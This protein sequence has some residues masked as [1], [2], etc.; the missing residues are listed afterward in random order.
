MRSSRSSD[1][2][3]VT[4]RFSLRLLLVLVTLLAMSCVCTNAFINRNR[5][6][7]LHE[8]AAFNDHGVARPNG[9]S[10]TNLD[11]QMTPILPERILTWLPV[12]VQEYFWRITHLDISVGTGFAD[13]FECCL[14][15]NRVEVVRVGAV[16]EPRDLLATLQGFPNL[17][18]L[19]V[20]C[21]D[22]YVNGQYSDL[23]YSELIPEYLPHVTVIREGS[24]GKVP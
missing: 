4:P 11:Y 16:W 19:E 9:Y 23:G 20:V 14:P 5:I 7:W 1:M 10:V 17:K 22:A 12:D 18:T 21:D 15:F 24:E 2:K 8:Q 3:F 13:D 6:E